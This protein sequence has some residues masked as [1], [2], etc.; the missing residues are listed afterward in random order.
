MSN[1]ALKTWK[2][3]E[4]IFNIGDPGGELHFIKEGEV[5]IYK[6][7]DN[8]EVEL[9][10][11]S[12]D[13]IIGVMTLF[14]DA[15]RTANAKAI[16]EVS[17]LVVSRQQIKKLMDQTP[18][19][20]K[21]LIKDLMARVDNA[22]DKFVASEK[23]LDQANRR[24][25]SSMSRALQVANAVGLI[26]SYIFDAGDGS[27]PIEYTEILQKTTYLFNE[28]PHDIDLFLKMFM[29]AGLINRDAKEAGIPPGRVVKVGKFSKYTKTLIESKDM[30]RKKLALTHRAF[31]TQHRKSSTDTSCLF[32]LLPSWQE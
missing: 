27:K 28:K 8:S 25:V 23:K 6:V 22:N 32:R 21:A 30:Y 26:G 31:P 7:V 4:V 2:A 18:D 29:E 19:W 17:S 13:E 1:D 9:A 24:R 14:S 10:T 12:K 16:S 20:M 3:G 15:R 5:S 11:L